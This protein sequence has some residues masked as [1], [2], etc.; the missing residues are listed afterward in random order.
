MVFRRLSAAALAARIDW[1]RLVL[2][3]ASWRFH[4]EFLEPQRQ[5]G[6]DENY[7]SPAVSIR[8]QA[9]SAGIGRD[10]EQKPYGILHR[11]R[12][13]RLLKFDEYSHSTPKTIPT[14]R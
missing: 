14:L 10:E 1:R 3:W 7:P 9:L 11:L 5:A 6:A 8:N 4:A 13:F 12:H 2:F